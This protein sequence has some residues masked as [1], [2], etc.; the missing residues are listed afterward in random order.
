MTNKSLNFNF[1][2]NV[3]IIKIYV[4]YYKIREDCGISKIYFYSTENNIDT[5]G[6]ILLA[7]IFKTI[8]NEP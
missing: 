8:T 1:N 4:G 2:F 5:E 7:F 6:N 3:W